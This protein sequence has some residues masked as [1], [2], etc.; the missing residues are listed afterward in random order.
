MSAFVRSLVR[1]IKPFSLRTLLC[2]V[3]TAAFA[4][5]FAAMSDHM[6]R[7]EYFAD[8]RNRDGLLDNCFYVYKEHKLFPWRRLVVAG[9]FANQDLARFA[10]GLGG[11][12][13]YEKTGKFEI[14]A[15]CPVRTSPPAFRSYSQDLHIDRLS[16]DLFEFEKTPTTCS[17]GL[18]DENLKWAEFKVS[19]AAL[20]RFLRDDSMQPWSINSLRRFLGKRGG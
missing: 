9:F 10:A 19:L 2:I 15:V 20:E 18:T 1:R 5:Y 17:E 6:Y 8:A 13:E 16:G 11:D 12:E 4:I 3:S 14:F 7:V